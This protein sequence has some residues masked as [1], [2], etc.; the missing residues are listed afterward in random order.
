VLELYRALI[1]LRRERPELADPWVADS[2][3]DSAPDGSWLV[4]H[5]GGLRLAVNFGPGP[6]T[7]PLGAT[8]SLLTWGEATVDGGAAHL[9]S[10]TFVVAETTP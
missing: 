3:V 6:V 2:R 7:L 9:P 10:D 5:R 4:L 1:R 8:V